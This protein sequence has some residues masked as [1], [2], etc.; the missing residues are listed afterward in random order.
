MDTTAEYEQPLKGCSLDLNARPV[1]TT[2]TEVVE[3]QI[4][5][6][7]RRLCKSQTEKVLDRTPR[8]LP[9]HLLRNF[10]Y[11]LTNQLDLLIIL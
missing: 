9:R 4:S 2:T 8:F 6:F 11:T 7:V 3:T 10:F 1:H 5:D